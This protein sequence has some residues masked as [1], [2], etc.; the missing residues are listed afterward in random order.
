MIPEFLTPAL[1]L[2]LRKARPFLITGRDPRDSGR[3]NLARYSGFD[4]DLGADQT[5]V[6]G[7]HPSREGAAAIASGAP[8]PDDSADTRQTLRTSLDFAIWSAQ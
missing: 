5:P 7:A 6:E 4:D 1:E 8:K 3:R 2:Y